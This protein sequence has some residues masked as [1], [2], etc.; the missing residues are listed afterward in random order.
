M[1]IAIVDDDWALLEL[2]SVIIKKSGHSV[3]A[4]SDSEECW[5]W[6]SNSS[7]LC[8]DALITDLMMPYYD[9]IE[10]IS[11]IRSETHCRNIPILLISS[12]D[13]IGPREDMWDIYIEKPFTRQ[14]LLEAL[15]KAITM[16]KQ[17]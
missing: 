11:K 6:I 17:S 14:Q 3:Y 13:S 15:D 7:N 16:R 9:G 5:E 2:V 4:F 8:P 12:I 1:I 10:L